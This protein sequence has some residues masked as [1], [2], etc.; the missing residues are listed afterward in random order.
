MKKQQNSSSTL[1]ITEVF[2]AKSPAL[3]Y[4]NS[5]GNFLLM[6]LIFEED[7]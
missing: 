6:N 4:N 1:K 5:V 3:L 7:F 2:L